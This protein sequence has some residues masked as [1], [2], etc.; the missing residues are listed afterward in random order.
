MSP[1]SRVFARVRILL[2]VY[3]HIRIKLAM[4]YENRILMHYIF[5]NQVSNIG[6]H[7]YDQIQILDATIIRINVIRSYSS[8]LNTL[9][10]YFSVLSTPLN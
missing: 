2:S 3:R 7:M 4:N 8:K 5:F 10:I 9:H 6:H 1:T